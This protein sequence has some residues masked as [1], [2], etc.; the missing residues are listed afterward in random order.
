MQEAA[1][2]ITMTEINREHPEFK[3]KREMW[4]MYRDL[5]LGGQEFKFRAADYLLRRQKE[6]LDV[7]GERL[8]RVFYENYIGSI[9]DWYAST[10]FRREPSLQFIGGLDSGKAFLA[11]LADDCHLRGTKLAAFF[12]R[13]F[14]DMLVAGRSH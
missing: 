9:I 1:R 13:S 11:E 5:Y 8:Y 7:Y 6:P 10:V 12:R 4:R 3:R 2:R 14:T